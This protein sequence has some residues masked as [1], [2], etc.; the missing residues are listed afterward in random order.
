MTTADQISALRQEILD[1][2]S[3]QMAAL[4]SPLGLSDSGLIACYRRQERVQD[5]RERLQGLSGS[6]C[7]VTASSQIAQV[8]G[9]ASCPVLP[10]E[11]GAECTV[12][13]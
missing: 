11:S 1:L 3:Q 10:P 13:I 8:E 5:L 12:R 2:L 6:T 4:D 9:E 7:I